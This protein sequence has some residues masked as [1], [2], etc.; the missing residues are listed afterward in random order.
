[1]ADNAFFIIKSASAANMVGKGRLFAVLA[2]G[3]S[4]FL[5]RHMR[6]FFG[7]ARVGMTVTGYG[8]GFK[9]PELNKVIFIH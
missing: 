4:F 8:H 3:E 6:A 1:L 7:G 2:K 9:S 5:F